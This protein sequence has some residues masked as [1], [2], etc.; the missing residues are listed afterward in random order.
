MEIN[1]SIIK[2]QK[3]K[4]KMKIVKNENEKQI[5]KNLISIKCLFHS[6]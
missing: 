1:V 3:L 2:K 4:K 5:K 6:F